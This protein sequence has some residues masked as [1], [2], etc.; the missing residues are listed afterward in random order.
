MS[1]V[2]V[3]AGTRSNRPTGRMYEESFTSGVK[4]G[5]WRSSGTTAVDLAFVV[6][7]FFYQFSILQR[8]FADEVE[9]LVKKFQDRTKPFA[10]RCPETCSCVHGA[11]TALLRWCLTTAQETVELA[12]TMENNI[13]PQLG[14]IAKHR[15][16][17][18]SEVTSYHNN[19]LSELEKTEAQLNKVQ[20]EYKNSWQK[21]KTEGN[22]K[23]LKNQSTVDCYTTFNEYLL[24]LAA[25]N[26]SHTTI[27][28]AAL[29]RT[30]SDLEAIQCDI[31]EA[32][33]FSL[34]RY[35]R[36]LQTQL[37]EQTSRLDDLISST[38][39]ANHLQVSQDLSVLAQIVRPE[40]KLFEFH[41]MDPD[42]QEDFVNNKLVLNE[43]TETTLREKHQQLVQ[44]VKDLERLVSDSRDSLAH[45]R[46]QLESQKSTEPSGS[47]AK[48]LS[49]IHRVKNNIRSREVWL[50]C[51]RTQLLL[52]RPDWFAVSSTL[53]NGHVPP[54]SS[55]PETSSSSAPNS[56]SS[57]SSHLLQE[58]NFIKTT[59]C[60]QCKAPLKGLMKQGLRC[61]VCKVC[62]H[63]KC[64]ESLP[65][66][67]ALSQE[68]GKASKSSSKKIFRRQNSVQDIRV[69]LA[70]KRKFLR[71]Q[72]SSSAL[73]IPEDI[74]RGRETEECKPSVTVDPVYETIKCAASLS[75]IAHSEGRPRSERRDSKISVLGQRD[76]DD[77]FLSPD[78]SSISL[79]K[80]AP[81][82]RLRMSSLDRYSQ[83]NFS[84]NNSTDLRPTN[85]LSSLSFHD[86]PS[87]ADERRKIL[88]KCGKSVSLDNE[89]QGPREGERRRVTSGM[90]VSLQDTS[91]PVRQS[92]HQFVVLY[93]FE[94][95]LRDDLTLRAGEVIRVLSGRNAEWWKGEV[96]GQVGFFPSFCVSPLYAN[97]SVMRVNTGF[98]ASQEHID[99]ISLRK[100]QIVI[101]TGSEENGWVK[102]RSAMKSGYFPLNYL[103]A[104][105]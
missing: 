7:D 99:G 57:S 104:V 58:Y 83:L 46:K 92:T 84:S 60:Y 88:Q 98:R 34:N 80:S 54:S 6:A 65:E 68:T 11:W 77:S 102:V 14:D 67:I 31:Q 8:R 30:V 96:D 101:V 94:G 64:Q 27:C 1:L 71:R 29:N 97:E 28:T 56:T 4:P 41:V 10:E 82:R 20:N 9:M 24:Q 90:A 42:G 52:F 89:Q 47:I 17:L 25:T 93:D 85:P 37:L 19:F 103:Q 38:K 76:E 75:S 22:V 69:S 23:D 91:K 86:S 12:N 5:K 15:K 73:E 55:N 36:L 62:V 18:L 44:Q 59:L 2:A 72:K 78:A 45:L 16:D 32:V 40:P 63:H 51:H 61:K 35:G 43:A 33:A 74:L 13:S 50:G 87:H 81:H 26:H 39:K 53:T 3:S 66:C 70:D 95:M 79:S 105:N 21:M 100:H 48:T 49:D